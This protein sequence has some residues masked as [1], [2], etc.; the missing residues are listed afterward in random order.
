MKNRKTYIAFF[1]PSMRGGGA[2][3]VFLNLANELIK[4]NYRVDMVLAQKE[5]PF[6]R[7]IS[8]KVNIIDLKSSRILKSLFPLVSYL[9]REKPEILLSS[10]N[11]VNIISIVSKII[12]RTSSKIIIKQDSYY[13][14]SSNRII[15]FLEKTLF[16][17]ADHIIA[18]SR[19]VKKSLMEILAIPDEKIK[20]I[21]NPIFNQDILKKSKEKINHS[22]FNNKK[23]KVILG[24]GRLSEVKDFSTLIKAFNMIKTDAMRLI[25]LGEGQYRSELENLIR[26]LGL[27]EYVSMPGFVDNPYAYMAKTDAFVISSL[28]EGLPNVLIEA[29]AC[30][31]NIISTDCPGGPSEILDG[32]KY[33]R[34]VPVGDVG[35]LAEAISASLD[36]PIDKGALLNRAKI[37]SIENAL[38]EYIKIFNE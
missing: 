28:R 1:I 9:Q 13:E 11:H 20:V 6:L 4:V 14:L 2:E 24:V 5:G 30:G 10:L 17:K 25:I 27:K 23:N 21:Y 37:F 18:V 26:E 32:G 36:S 38:E 16:K 3:R 12:S 7:D 8:S 29:L 33:G 15:M 35:K 31:A 34:L 22:F 19:D